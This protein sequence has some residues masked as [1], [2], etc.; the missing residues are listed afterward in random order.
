MMR[1][2]M[3]HLSRLIDP[4]ADLVF[5]NG[6]KIVSKA[7]ITDPAVHKFMGDKPSYSWFDYR[8]KNE[9]E[10]IELSVALLDNFIDK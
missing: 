10:L 2:Q 9:K 8:N 4:Y 7:L 3:R 6:P 1:A 5:A